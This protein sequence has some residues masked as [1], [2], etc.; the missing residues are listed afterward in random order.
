MYKSKLPWIE[1]LMEQKIYSALIE[2]EMDS[3][4]WETLYCLQDD[5]PFKNTNKSKQEI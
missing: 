1:K 5:V 4:I 2:M 3:Q